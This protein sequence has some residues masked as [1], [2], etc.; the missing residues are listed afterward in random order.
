EYAFANPSVSEGALHYCVEAR[1]GTAS[2]ATVRLQSIACPMDGGGTPDKLLVDETVSVPANSSRAFDYVIPWA[3]A[4]LWDTEN[5]FLYRIRNTLFNGSEIIDD[6]ED[7]FGFREFTIRGH[8]YFLNGRKVRLFGQSGH[9]GP[10]HNALSLEQKISFFRDWKNLGNVNHV[11]LHARVQ[12]KEWVVAADRTGMLITT[13]TALWTTNMH[14]FDFAGS[15]QACFENVRNHF[16]EALVKRDRNNPSVVIWSLANE[17]SPHNPSHMSHPKI[18]A[19][20]R[21]YKRIID[22]ATALDKS[23]VLQISSASD[24]LGMLSTYN[25]HY[26]KSWQA[27]P[28]YPN[29]AYWI[30]SPWMFPWNRPDKSILASWQWRRDK[31]L[32]IGEFSCVFGAT[33]DRQSTV[34]GDAAFEED[35]YGTGLV[36]EKIWPMEIN[37]YRRRDVSG[38]CP[39]VS[40][41]GFDYTD[42][43]EW[44][45]RPDNAAFTYAQRP[46]ALISHGYA[47]D[48]FSGDE[49]PVPLSIHN[50]G[51]RKKMISYRLEVFDGDKPIWSESAP[52]VAFGPAETAELTCRFRVPAYAECKELTLKALME[53]DGETADAWD[54]TFKIHPRNA[55][56]TFSNDCAFFDPE[57]IFEAAFDKRG[58]AGASFVGELD[59][60]TDYSRYKSIWLNFKT[61]KARKGDWEKNKARLKSFVRDGGC[62]ILDCADFE[63]TG[64]PIEPKNGKGYAE[65]ERLEITYAYVS[66]PNHPAVGGLSDDCFSLWGADYYVARRC[67]QIPEK[68]NSTPLLVAGTDSEG[69]TK[70]PLFEIRLGMG[71]FFVCALEL[72]S[73]LNEAPIAAR[74]IKSIADYSP[75]REP[76]TTRACVGDETLNRMKE[77]GFTGESVTLAEALEADVSVIDGKKICDGDFAPI[78]RAVESGKTVCL[79]ALYEASTRNAMEVFSIEGDVMPGAIEKGKWDAIRHGNR[80]S[81]GMTSG[82]LF[83]IVGK[84]RL[85]MWVPATHHPAPASALIKPSGERVAS[86]LTKRGAAAAFEFG[87]GALI[88]D[89]LRWESG[90]I[91]EPE[92]PRRYLSNLL[93]NMGVALS[94]GTADEEASDFETAV[95]KR[96]R[97]HF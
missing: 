45:K 4:V 96:E 47:T 67:Y 66:A 91:D 46:L 25:L 2:D 40:M 1:N 10:A 48:Y 52:A 7:Y 75:W 57:G 19:M 73:K 80:F 27:Y 21:I 55:G 8:S 28:D 60:E 15:E 33:P 93:T 5:P 30:D 16:I 29:T 89:N 35:D 17:M 78:K 14:S 9:I 44:L 51:A 63:L 70:T 59:G 53:A 72:A 24:Y 50:D 58:I 22:E 6:H 39:W 56:L 68:G 85:A 18:A 69:L 65:G 90:E 61:A 86:L 97:G 81:D 76:K 62:V 64:L 13:E 92:R 41:Y 32:Y 3:D 12:D 54:K 82:S 71:S 95:E 88:I 87:G 37:A 94:S 11:R 84:A 42:V 36:N 74:L 49:I 83:W 43:S 20:T 34:V 79:H 38:F 77:I 31:P 23:R 26:P